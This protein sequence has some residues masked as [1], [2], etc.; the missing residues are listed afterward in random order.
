[1]SEAA[2]G[3][4]GSGKHPRFCWTS[5]GSSERDVQGMGEGWID[6]LETAGDG[7]SDFDLESVS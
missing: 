7:G 3:S 4:P 5:S 2:H 1:M 6:E